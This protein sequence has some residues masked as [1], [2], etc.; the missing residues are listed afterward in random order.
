M[1]KN[2]VWLLASL[3]SAFSSLVFQYLSYFFSGITTEFLF[4]AALPTYFLFLSI[5]F[6]S[7]YY[8][9]VRFALYIIFPFIFILSL[10]LVWVITSFFSY[11]WIFRFYNVT[12]ILFIFSFPLFIAVSV[13]Y[14]LLTY[15]AVP[16]IPKI[17][18]SLC[19]EI[20]LMLMGIVLFQP[21]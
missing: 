20:L 16:Q 9:R 3:I 7:I 8:K 21:F 17:T 5:F 1:K 2:P 12:D 19:L 4:L 13:L 10:S 6:L 11:S 18:L 15:F 14:A